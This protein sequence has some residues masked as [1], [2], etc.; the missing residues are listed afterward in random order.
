MRW[1]R[2]SAVLLA[3]VMCG[4]RVTAEVQPLTAIVSSDFIHAPATYP[5]CHA[6]TLVETRSGAVVAAWFGGTREGASDVSIWS[7]RSE[8]GRWSAETK[9][10]D[11]VET[12]AARYPCW[13]PVLF[14]PRH[15]PLL[16]FFKVG[17]SPSTWWGMVA[18]STDDGRT[19]SKPRRLPDGVLGPIK[20]KPIE[21][22]DGTLL[23]GSSTEDEKLGWRVHIE[24]SLDS[25]QSWQRSAALETSESLNAIQP[26]LLTHADG[27]I[28]LLCRTK[29][30]VIATSWSSDAGRTWSPLTKSGLFS[31]NS[32]LD[33][34]TLADGRHLL[35]YN[36]REN[37]NDGPP[38][39]KSGTLVQS[40]ADN[41]DRLKARWPLNVA[42][43][44]D[45]VTWKMVLVLEDVPRKEGYAYPAVIQT[46][47][48]LIHI[49][50]TWDR[51]K[52]K[53]VVLN[54]QAL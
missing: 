3:V 7:S 23:S 47:D 32:G 46:H 52:I 22:P 6:S 10:A 26:A 19:W 5:Q 33:A 41:I 30:R 44:S 35:V 24:R 13:N 2:L 51:V 37:A 43:S 49:S 14:Q 16:L 31:P 9:V 20:N 38:V 27:R 28:Q 8:A 42:V 17:P 54:P 11:G 34:V 36:H 40:P 1:T 25:G 18:T 45:G 21:L 4:G 29:E 15:G 12:G 50:Y 39:P 53:H 48:G